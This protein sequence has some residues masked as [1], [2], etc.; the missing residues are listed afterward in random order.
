MAFIKTGEGT[1]IGVVKFDALT[2]EQKKLAEQT[3]VPNNPKTT[4]KQE[5]KKENN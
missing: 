4:E 5:S 2:E 3:K 1:I